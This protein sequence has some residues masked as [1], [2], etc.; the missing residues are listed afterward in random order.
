VTPKRTR[1]ETLKK[2]FI[3]SFLVLALAAC[4]KPPMHT[5]KYELNEQGWHKDSVFT[6]S[7]EVLD[8]INPYNFFLHLRH[9]AKY[10]YANCYF[11]VETQLPNK[12]TVIDTVECFVAK[13]S[14][15]WIGSGLGDILDNKYIFKFNKRFP[16]GGLYTFKIKQ[17]M[18]DTLLPAIVNVG[19]SI[20]QNPEP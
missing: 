9:S 7:V 1:M 6:S 17:G 3:L 14:G 10:P 11:F 18:R 5:A 4:T 16:S 2:G 20:E 13:P 8:T 19:L 15:E 12:T